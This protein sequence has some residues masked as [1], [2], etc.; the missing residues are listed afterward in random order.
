MVLRVNSTRCSKEL[1]PCI[2]EI[3]QNEL[4]SLLENKVCAKD[5]S[6]CIQGPKGDRGPAGVPGPP[7]LPGEQGDRGE[8][9]AKGEKGD[10]GTRYQLQWPGYKLV[11]TY[12]PNISQLT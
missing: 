6:V 10:S 12:E 7:G 5:E 8:P 2:Q 11:C 1:A 4:R 9:G 3:T